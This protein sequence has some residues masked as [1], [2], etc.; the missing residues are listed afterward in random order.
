MGERVLGSL[1]ALLVVTGFAGAQGPASSLPPS[2]PA[3]ASAAS[4]PDDE[5]GAFGMDGP[6]KP[7]VTCDP[8]PPP[9]CGPATWVDAEFLYWWVKN[10]PL[11]APLLTTGPGF[12]SSPS[13]PGSLSSPDTQILAGNGSLDMGQFPGGRFSFGTWLSGVPHLGFDSLGLEASFLFLGRQTNHLEFDGGPSTAVLARPYFDTATGQETTFPVAGPKPVG[14]D[15]GSLVMTNSTELWGAEANAFLP[16]CGK[17]GLLFGFLAG[18]RYLNIEES[19]NLDQTTTTPVATVGSF[20]GSPVISPLGQT[21]RLFDDFDTRNNYYG[22]QLGTQTVFRYGPLA[23]TALTKV[24]LGTTHETVDIFGQSTLERPGVTPVSTSGGLLALNSNIGNYGHYQFAV[25]PE[26]TLNVCYQLSS[27]FALSAGYTFLYVSSV[28]RPGPQID[29][30]INPN[31][32]PTAPA[33]G[34]SSGGEARPAFQFNS[35][36]FWAQG[37]TMGLTVTW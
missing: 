20:G 4:V 16:V 37:L 23:I 30:A 12:V 22:A 33:I 2:C 5:E 36:D 25:V 8:G 19:L 28:V 1:A 9:G 17:P 32:L 24:A 11:P 27:N 26:G 6:C 14:G 35:S 31:F 3:A 29:R 13:H 10:A 34:L 21:L 18:F 7:N 15:T